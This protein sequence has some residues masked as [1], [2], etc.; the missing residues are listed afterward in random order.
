[1]ASSAL[2]LGGIGYWIDQQRQHETPYLG[3][4][5]VLLGF[6]LGMYRLIRVAKEVGGG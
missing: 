4:A 2:I 5:G 1:M 6:V 3:V